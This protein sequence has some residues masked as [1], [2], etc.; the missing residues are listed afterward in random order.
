MKKIA[1][2]SF[3]VALAVFALSF[4]SL[5]QDEA[6]TEETISFDEESYNFGSITQ[7]DKVE[8]TFTFTNT[9]TE[10]IVIENVRASCGCTTPVKPEGPVLPGQTEELKVVFNSAGKMG[11]QN[12]A[13][14][15]TSNAN[16]PRKVIY[17][18]GEVKAP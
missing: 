10:P 15:I 2:Q 7:G 12:K 14:T 1:L 5:A 13:I 16:P 8:H 18:K 9:G 11:M 4:Q 6:A 17:L 3:W